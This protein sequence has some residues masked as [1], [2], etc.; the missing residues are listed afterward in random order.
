MKIPLLSLCLSLSSLVFAQT[1]PASIP[2][3]AWKL[4]ALDQNKPAIGNELGVTNPNPVTKPAAPVQAKGVTE[5]VIGETFYDLQTNRSMAD[6]L[7]MRSDGSFGALWTFS[8]DGNGY[9]DRGTGYNNRSTGG[10]WDAV[11]TTRIENVR[12]GWPSN[13]VTAAGKEVVIAHDFANYNLVMSE[14]STPGTGAWTQTTIPDVSGD[15]MVWCRAATGGANGNS[16]HLIASTQGVSLGGNTTSG[17]D[18]TV[19]YYRSQDQGATW[20]VNA[21]EF[22]GLDSANFSFVVP[23]A[24]SIAS[25]GDNVVVALFGAMNDIMLFK[26]ADNGTTWT[27]TVVMDFPIDRYV[28]DGGSDID[29]DNVD[30]TVACWDGFG[31]LLLDNNGMAHLFWGNIRVLDNDPQ[32]GGWTYFPVT[33]GLSYWNEG[34]LP[35]SSIMIAYA[36]DV[37]GDQ[38]LGFAGEIVLYGCGLTSMPTSG[39]NADGT[40]FLVYSSHY[41][42]LDNGTQNYRHLYGMKSHDGGGTWS[43]PI[44]LTPDSN[45]EGLES[46][47]PEMEQNV[48]DNVYLIYQRDWEPG[49]M[50][51]GDMDLSGVNEIIFLESDTLFGVGVS[52]NEQQMTAGNLNI[53]P[54]PTNDASFISI[55]LEASAQLNIKGY[56]LAGKEVAVI[57]EGRLPAGN[58]IIEVST[59]GWATGI[60]QLQAVAGSHVWNGRLVKKN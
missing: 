60:Y 36:E 2:A 3:N 4:N 8:L 35:N 12:T 33:D 30:D 43:T 7:L 21:M 5:T 27:S 16:I 24:Y 14:R 29:N 54:N 17:I 26:S 10:V 25:Q 45:S 51:Q 28:L 1:Q 44:D 38:Q 42:S 57:F 59:E 49:G 11:P 20:D 6:R 23:D 40:I 53:Y 31:S 55:D 46:V 58:Q 39:I 15:G 34:M 22:P 48:T 52:I 56:D 50:V 37:D 47:Y 19:L 9:P 41:E 13:L 18:R 32:D